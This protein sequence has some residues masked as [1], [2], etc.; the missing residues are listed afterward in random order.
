[1]S[2]VAAVPILTYNTSRYDDHEST[3][4]ATMLAR[5]LNTRG[6]A[7]VVSQVLSSPAHKSLFNTT[8]YV[9][10]RMPGLY[11][12][13]VFIVIRGGFEN[14]SFHVRVVD[15]ASDEQAQRLVLAAIQDYIRTFDHS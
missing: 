14:P 2:L 13:S 3:T 1:M 8:Q 5:H 7:A 4:L 9:G 15:D 6:I 11:V 12:S 10:E